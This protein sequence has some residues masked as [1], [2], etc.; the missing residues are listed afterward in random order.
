[1]LLS[2]EFSELIILPFAAAYNLTLARLLIDTAAD[3]HGNTSSCFKGIVTHLSSQR[4]WWW[5]GWKWYH[6]SDENFWLNHGEK[7][8]MTLQ[9][10][11]E[12]TSIHSQSLRG[13]KRRNGQH[14]SKI[15]KTYLGHVDTY[16]SIMWPP[17]PP[18]IYPAPFPAATFS[19][20]EPIPGIGEPVDLTW[21]EVLWR[22]STFP[23]DPK[24]GGK[25]WFFNG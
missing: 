19:L 20:M 25:W 13:I 9:G 15:T 14:P 22:F 3:E 2:P 4:R 8:S 17:D 11:C 16:S 12:M 1:M 7:L 23:K 6:F 24:I 18:T 10:N 5:A 21:S